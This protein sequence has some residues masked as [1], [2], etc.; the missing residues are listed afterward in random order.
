MGA[1]F[2]HNANITAAPPT[3]PPSVAQHA[4]P[5][6][7][8]TPHATRVLHNR[9]LSSVSSIMPRQTVG[10]G[11]TLRGNPVMA[12]TAE[13]GGLEAA[14]MGAEGATGRCR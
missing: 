5:H 2:L 8:S 13:M 12:R 10:R 9:T 11:L 3:P 14:E 4:S 6:T 1:V 7:V